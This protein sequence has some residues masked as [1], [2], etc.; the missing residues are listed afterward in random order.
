MTLASLLLD[1]PFGDDEYLLHTA[2]SSV[3]AGE[4]RATAQQTAVD[5]GPL[6]GRG[7]AVQL[8][9]GP[10]LVTTMVQQHRTMCDKMMQMHDHKMEA[11]K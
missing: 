3:T 8:P 11:Q 5:L 4:A 9:N 10:D 1:H 2:T 7:V 6:E